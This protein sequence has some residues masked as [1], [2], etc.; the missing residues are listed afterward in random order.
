VDWS[1]VSRFSVSGGYSMEDATN[2]LKARYRTGAVGSVTDDN[3]TYRWTNTN[4]DKNRTAYASVTAVLI[5]DK[6]DFVGNM[7]NINA[8]FWLYNVNPTTP[9]GGTAAQNLSATVENWPKVT[10]NLRP[11]MLSL[12]YRH[13]PDWA[14]TLRYQAEQYEQTDFRTSMPQFA[15]FT[16]QTGNLPGS[17]GTVAGSNTGQYHFLGNNYLPYTAHWFTILISYHPSALP[18]SKARSTL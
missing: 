8:H 13:S 4:T 14:F 15:P 1:P 2:I 16:G 17:I 6:L 11:A 18:F 10:Q 12:R 7:S 9:T 3:P 5:P